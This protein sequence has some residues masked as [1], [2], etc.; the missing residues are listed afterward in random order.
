[1]VGAQVR[2]AHAGQ[3]FK[4]GRGERW[5]SA[6]RVHDTVLI[7]H[8]VGIGLVEHAGRNHQVRVH[9]RQGQSQDDV[10]VP[11]RHLFASEYAGAVDRR[12]FQQVREIAAFIEG[13]QV[14]GGAVAD[15]ERSS[16]RGILVQMNQV[17]PP[18]LGHAVGN[19]PGPVDSAIHE[20]GRRI[21]AVDAGEGP[22]SDQLLVALDD[23]ARSIEGPGEEGVVEV[24]RDLGRIHRRRF[25]GPRVE[26]RNGR[27]NGSRCRRAGRRLLHAQAVDA[28][29]GTVAREAEFHTVV[30][31]H[32]AAP[33]NLP[34]PAGGREVGPGSVPGADF[35]IAGAVNQGR[36]VSLVSAV[37]EHPASAGEPRVG[38]VHPQDLDVGP[39]EDL[40]GTVGAHHGQHGYPDDPAGARVG[41]ARLGGHWQERPAPALRL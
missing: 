39:Q 4:L 30:G 11:E 14:G 28:P 15:S 29:A 18:F 32:H 35:V 19:A 33:I 2:I 3:G 17:R 37:R 41:S 26:E 23:G 12:P 22:A 16:I 31:L 10:R 27:V 36:T 13:I 9:P 5:I 1:M 8:R 7:E 21:R 20:G 40:A 34:Y 6:G 25:D 38:A 24:V